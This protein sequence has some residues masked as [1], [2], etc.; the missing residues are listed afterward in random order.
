MTTPSNNKIETK[1]SAATAGAIVS[2]FLVYL[3]GEL[4]F[5]GSEVPTPVIAI[6]Q[7]AVVGVTT[8]VSGYA[9]PHTARVTPPSD[10]NY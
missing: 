9:A 3:L 7:L 5:K 6:I 8:F 4:V 2:A 10:T 1:V